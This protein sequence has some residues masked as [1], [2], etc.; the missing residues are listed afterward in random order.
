MNMESTHGGFPFD[1][2]WRHWSALALLMS[3]VTTLNGVGQEVRPVN[4]T[5]DAL[6]VNRIYNEVRGVVLSPTKGL[7]VYSTNKARLLFAGTQKYQDFHTKP[8]VIHS[9]TE[10]PL[11]PLVCTDG[12]LLQFEVER[13]TVKQFKTITAPL[14]SLYYT[15]AKIYFGGESA[16]WEG[17]P[18]L[19]LPLKLILSGF[20]GVTSLYYH[21]N[22]LWIGTSL[23]LFRANK[24]AG[25]WVSTRMDKSTLEVYLMRFSDNALYV[26][27]RNGLFKYSNPHGQSISPKV[28]WDYPT[29]QFLRTGSRLWLAT[30]TG[31]NALD[32]GPPLHVYP[33][34]SDTELISGILSIEK[35]QDLLMLGTRRGLFNISIS[36]KPWSQKVNLK[37]QRRAY[38]GDPVGVSWNVRDDEHRTW[39][40]YIPVQVS[41]YDAREGL[42]VS[43]NVKGSSVALGPYKPGSYQ[44]EVTV[45]DFSG[46]SIRSS[47][48]RF[49]VIKSPLD[50]FLLII[51]NVTMIYTS[52][53]MLLFLFLVYMAPNNST[54][55]HFLF[56]PR[57]RKFGIFFGLA[58]QY[59]PQVRNWVFKGYFLSCKA[60]S[61][62]DHEHIPLAI[63]TPEQE[64]HQSTDMLS[65]FAAKKQIWLSGPSG[66]GKSEVSKLV[67]E[68]YFGSHTLLD[69]WKTYRFIPILVSVR[70]YKESEMMELIR[71]ALTSRGIPVQDINFVQGL[72]NTK[73]FALF[74]DG[75]NES[76]LEQE[77]IE[78]FHWRSSVPKFVTSQTKPAKLKSLTYE[79]RCLDSNFAQ[80][81]FQ[82]FLKKEDKKPIIPPEFWD[83]VK[84]VFDLRLLMRLVQSNKLVPDT[85]AGLYESTYEMGIEGKVADYEIARFAFTIWK[86]GSRRFAPDE[87]LTLSVLQNL[88]ESRVVIKQDQY[89]EFRHDLMRGYAAARWLGIH[90]SSDEILM[91]KFEDEAI[92]NLSPPE[93]ELV[94]QFLVA[95]VKVS[96]LRRLATFAF[97]D[98]KQKVVLLDSIRKAPAMRGITIEFL[99]DEG[100]HPQI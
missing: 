48:H 67:L 13:Q 31:L 94:F 79:L 14:L 9:L 15:P 93:Q 19:K 24:I 20:D 69:A 34:F 91:Q 57:V 29:Y 77:V 33:I 86:T 64:M 60:I 8:Y 4:Q 80:I 88:M 75:V 51:K 6:R 59:V 47:L 16:V 81:I 92:W 50:I 73:A 39:L 100:D 1:K 23:G 63:I 36:E 65:R 87:H 61:K 99:S 5:I 71:K 56:D 53:A 3:M 37:V 11:G 40:D 41:V 96:T 45:H 54:A 22:Y 58:V 7:W 74:L 43:T 12:G 85:R 49:D 55:M 42:L 78:W 2:L 30:S 10:T 46:H 35:Y 83:D 17:D 68:G 90:S 18:Q 98:T 38:E 44:V 89:Y 28:L 52:A 62:L 84:T 26:G 27:C 25:K 82:E 97:G 32:E 76:E 21:N 95:M 66:V 72:L 70:D